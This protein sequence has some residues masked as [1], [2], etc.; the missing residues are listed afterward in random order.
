MMRIDGKTDSKP[1][2]YAKT[3]V[4]ACLDF[5]PWIRV[6]RAFN[7]KGI[8]QK[9]IDKLNAAIDK[10]NDSEDSLNTLSLKMDV[11]IMSLGGVKI[12]PATTEIEDIADTASKEYSNIC[13]LK[14]MREDWKPLNFD[15]KEHKDTYILEGEACEAITAMLDDHLIKTQTMKGSPYAAFMLEPI[16]EWEGTLERTQ[17][18]LETWVSVQST[19]RYLEPVFSSED[20]MNQMRQHGTIFR[21]VDREWKRLM[22]KVANDPSSA[23]IWEIDGLGPLLKAC[24]IKLEEVTKGLNQYLESKQ[25]LFPRFYFLSNEELLEILSETKE[26]TL[27]QP[28]IH[29]CMEGIHELI[30]DEDKKILGMVSAEGEKVSFVRVI[31]PVAARGNVE[32]WLLQ[33][34]ETMIKTV[35]SQTDMCLQDYGKRDR[36]KW[37]IAGWPGMAIIGVD[38]MQWT[39]GGEEAMKKNGIAGLEMYYDK[40]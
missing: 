16:L 25:G 33:V 8:E 13:L 7:T 6:I 4:K 12:T 29:K 35:K 34:E 10:A 24:Q 22:A 37:V 17:D 9:H 36:E 32:E 40:L 23:A 21:E 18:F 31:D 3:M 11:P 19:W 2:I 27:V 30:F 5:E 20:L 39:Q 26:P 38:M 28:H 1:V 15:V 14:T